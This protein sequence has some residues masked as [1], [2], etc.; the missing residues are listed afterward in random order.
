MQFLL[1]LEVCMMGDYFFLHSNCLF[2]IAVF[3]GM[4]ILHSMCFT[5]ISCEP[6]LISLSHSKGWL[7]AL[8]LR[9]G[10]INNG[11]LAGDRPC[12]FPCRISMSVSL[13]LFPPTP[14]TS[15]QLSNNPKKMLFISHQEKTILTTNVLQAGWETKTEKFL[16]S[17]VDFPLTSRF[18]VHGP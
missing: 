5:R 16:N 12:V 3:R 13:W 18:Q 4:C 9:M 7:E 2:Q 1:S 17:V 6:W 14:P 15:F 10:L 8:C 11:L